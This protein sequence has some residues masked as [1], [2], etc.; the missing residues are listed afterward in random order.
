MHNESTTMG[1]DR[2]G[3]GFNQKGPQGQRVGKKGKKKDGD[4]NAKSCAQQV[5]RNLH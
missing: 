3:K 5:L 1:G 4:V 2:K